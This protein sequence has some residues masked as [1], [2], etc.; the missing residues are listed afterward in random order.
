DDAYAKSAA[1]LA[2]TN[3]LRTYLLKHPPSSLHQSGMMLWASTYLDGLADP[4]TRDQWMKE[5]FAA[6]GD[7]G[8]WVLP[9]LGN[10]DWKRSD[11]KPQ[12][13]DSDAYATAFSV[14]VLTEAGVPRDDPR[15]RKAL[16]W[17]RGNQRRSGRWFTR[18]P[19]RDN[20]H[21]ISHAATNFALLA[22]APEAGQGTGAPQ[23]RPPD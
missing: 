14:H 2:G 11:G 10:D 3:R 20:K 4:K 5:L 6:Q 13:T 15:I 8:G 17:L 22:L 12:S 7:D 1:A 9:A 16:R 18:S 21:Y 23:V 19:R